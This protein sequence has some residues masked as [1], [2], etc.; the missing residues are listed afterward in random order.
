MTVTLDSAC[1]LH[2]QVA[3]RPEPFGALAYH[4]GNRKLVFLKHPDVVAVLRDVAAHDTLADTL[5]AH[6]V[7]PELWNS[8]VSALSSL[9]TSEIIRVRQ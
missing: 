2:P 6:N 4:Y 7:A 8:F 5:V 1:E 3:L 9:E